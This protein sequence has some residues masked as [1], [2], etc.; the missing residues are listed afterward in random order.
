MWKVAIITRELNYHMV[1][2]HDITSIN[3][4]IID[5]NRIM[6][7]TTILLVDILYL[8]MVGFYISTTTH[9]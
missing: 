6:H 3:H 8:A 2:K 7:F 4:S 9:N 1:S 5:K